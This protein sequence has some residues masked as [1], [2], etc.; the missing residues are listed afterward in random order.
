MSRNAYL[1]ATLELKDQADFIER[2]A[3][4]TV[5]QLES[6]GAEVLVAGPDAMVM[7]GEWPGNWTVVIRFPDLASARAWYASTEYQP[8]KRLRAEELTASGSVVF[9]EAFDPG[10]F[11]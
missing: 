4:P 2:Y 1:I 10:A 5:A 8:L 3:T 11:V 7:E 6:A 9:T